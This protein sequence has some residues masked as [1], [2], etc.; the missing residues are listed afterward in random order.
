MKKFKIFIF[1]F[2]IM[3]F[4]PSSVVFAETGI[5]NEAGNID[6]L[7]DSSSGGILSE[8]NLSVSDTESLMSFSLNDAFSWIL[9][10]AK[11]EITSP[12]KL[13]VTLFFILIISSLT[14]NMYTGKSGDS[15]KRTGEAAG[16]L[17]CVSV[18]MTPVSE[19][20]MNAAEV[21]K[22]GGS[23]MLA[24]VPV[25]AGAMVASGNITS[26]GSYNIIMLSIC[27]ISVQFASSFLIPLL[28][29][30]FCVSIVDSFNPSI[31]LSGLINGMKKT[32]T[33]CLGLLMTVF[34]GLLSLQ[35]ITGGAVDSLTVK[36]GKYLVSNLVPIV[37][38]A[39][40]DAYSTVNGSLGIL[41]NGI[42]TVGIVSIIIIVVPPVI[43]IMIFRM[44][45]SISSTFAD[46]MSCN[47]LKKLFSDLESV[48][49]IVLS[50]VSVFLIMLLVSTVFVMKTGNGG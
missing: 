33:L 39:V 6:A 30:C 1:I 5:E 40:S 32:V 42:G 26:S 47:R 8:N 50:I 41:R 37:G 15:C 34:T 3:I 46:V 18:L 17:V 14:Q 24:Y 43:K 45:L 20:F 28:S 7:L 22:D 27:E 23:F 11:K 25:M 29:L 48:Y 44:V 12:L 10:E 16:V 35:N 2:A 19:C 9:S 38:K 21:L 49:G 13:F 36:T 4:M 31:S